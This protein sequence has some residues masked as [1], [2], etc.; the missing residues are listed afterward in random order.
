MYLSIRRGLTEVLRHTKSC[1]QTV[2]RSCS[3]RAWTSTSASTI[4][5]YSYLVLLVAF[6]VPYYKYTSFCRTHTT[7]ATC[8][9]VLL[10][11]VHLVHLVLF[12]AYPHYTRTTPTPR[13]RSQT[14]PTYTPRP[15][16]LVR[17][18]TP[19]PC[20]PT[21]AN[22]TCT[23]GPGA[24]ALVLLILP[25]SVSIEGFRRRSRLLKL[26]R[27]RKKELN[28]RVRIPH[29]RAKSLALIRQRP[30]SDELRVTTPSWLTTDPLGLSMFAPRHDLETCVL[31]SPS[32][33]TSC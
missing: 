15:L 22:T 29:S 18:Y 3:P 5:S 14:T 24:L 32:A 16:V 23:P 10:P 30:W 26:A 20:T 1:V 17:S 12:Y 6:L 9:L 11:L 31:T 4:H 19:C 7:R 27:A 21:R 8:A 25:S 28:G 33:K 2:R 13:P